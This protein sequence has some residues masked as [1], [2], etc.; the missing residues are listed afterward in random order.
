MIVTNRLSNKCVR[1]ANIAISKYYNGVFA[2]STNELGRLVIMSHLWVGGGSRKSESQ[3]G[4]TIS[5]GT[6]NQHH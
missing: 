6:G 3:F 1:V 5:G 4:V 2:N